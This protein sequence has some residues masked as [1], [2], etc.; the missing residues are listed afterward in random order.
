MLIKYLWLEQ[1]KRYMDSDNLD[2]KKTLTIIVK[3]HQLCLNNINKIF[4]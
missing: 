2:I 1:K 4:I 3:S